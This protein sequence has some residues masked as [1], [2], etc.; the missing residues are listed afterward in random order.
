MVDLEAGRASVCYG[1]CLKNKRSCKNVTNESIISTL[2]LLFSNCHITFTYTLRFLCLFYAFQK[3]VL[4]LC[5]WCLVTV[6]LIT[7]KDIAEM[8]CYAVKESHEVM[9]WELTMRRL[10][11]HLLVEISPV[12]FIPRQ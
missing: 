11:A 4:L 1:S 6:Q 5:F 10:L 8:T 12:A 3:R 2:M 7:R 9:F